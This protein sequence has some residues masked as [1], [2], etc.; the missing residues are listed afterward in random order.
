LINKI[1]E[2]QTDLIKMA[3]KSILAS[4]VLK[5]MDKDY[6]YSKALKKVLDENRKKTKKKLEKN[7]NQ[8]I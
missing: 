8:Y 4:K 2:I 6:S 5:L 1:G 7:L 3:R